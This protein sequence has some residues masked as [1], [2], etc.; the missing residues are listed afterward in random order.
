[1]TSGSIDKQV[2]RFIACIR[3]YVKPFLLV[4][5]IYC[6]A[7]LSIWRAGVSYIDDN[8]RA[9]AGYAWM[10]DFNRYSQSILSYILNV[11]VELSD[12]SPFPQI[13]AMA[14][15]A[16]SSVIIT[17]V[18]CN[19]QIKTLPLILSTFIG[20]C[21]FTITCWLYKFDAPGM[22]LGVLASSIPILFWHSLTASSRPRKWIFAAVVTLASL[23]IMWTSYQPFG[24]VFLV[25]GIGLLFKEVIDKTPWRITLVKTVFFSCLYLTSA[26]LF[27]L[28]P[29]NPASYR[30][31]PMIKPP[32]ILH[33]LLANVHKH[34]ETIL[35]I[36]N[37]EWSFWLI[38]LAIWFG[39]SLLIYSRRKKIARVIDLGA[40]ALFVVLAVPLSFGAL[41]FLQTPDFSSRFLA[42]TGAVLAVMAIMM[43]RNIHARW[44]MIVSGAPALVLLYSFMVFAWA[45]GNGLADQYQYATFR[46]NTLA[47]DLARLYPT[48][49]HFADSKLQIQGRIGYSQVMEH[50]SKEYPIISN[51]ISSDQDGLADQAWGTFRLRYY[52]KRGQ[53]FTGVWSQH[54][55]CRKMPIELD[56]FYH[57][58]R[59]NSHGKMCVVL[60]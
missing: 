39:L 3:P 37:P 11:S 58:I 47:G 23:M 1:M 26:I 36:L 5:A 24:G 44:Q 6:I 7:M 33:G 35:S 19:K 14:F 32:Q 34:T 40:G 41:L 12:I 20:L 10:T 8:G 25:L 21:P 53:D 2:N 4:F 56:T 43:T 55:D 15:L 22:A 31:T 49:G 60:K 42:G 51:T 30:A 29:V 46:T 52:Y 48:V 9:I 57:T 59:S 16:I 28:I 45:F 38:V 13:V 54:W 17:Y 18:F 50:V 27:K